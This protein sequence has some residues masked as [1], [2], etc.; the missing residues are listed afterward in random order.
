MD[1][2]IFIILVCFG[3]NASAANWVSIGNN[4]ASDFYYDSDSIKPIIYNGQT[5]IKA[6]EKVVIKKPTS[7]TKVN[8]EMLSLTY[9]DCENRLS[10]AKQIVTRRNGKIFDDLSSTINSPKLYDLVPESASE[11][12]L[13]S[14][15]ADYQ[16]RTGTRSYMKLNGE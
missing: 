3:A 15:C 11:K 14:V 12:M 5:I 9:F 8:D 16:I 10:G 2:L 13:E 4:D 1:K 6:W 7:K